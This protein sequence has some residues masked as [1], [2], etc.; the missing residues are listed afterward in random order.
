ME[1]ELRVRSDVGQFED[2]A[3][4]AGEGTFVGV[5]IKAT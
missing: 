5:W 2:F 4:F 1:R 3:G